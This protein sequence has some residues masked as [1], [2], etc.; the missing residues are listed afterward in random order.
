MNKGI[1]SQ[2]Q[3]QQIVETTNFSYF[4][5][6]SFQN[7]SNLTQN[8]NE[9]LVMLQN[10]LQESIQ[11]AS[12][13]YNQLSSH[14][15]KALTRLEEVK[16]FEIDPLLNQKQSKINNLSR[17]NEHQVNIKRQLISQELNQYVVF[18]KSL[19]K[20]EVDISFISQKAKSLQLSQIERQNLLN[21]YIKDNANKL[22]DQ[23]L[24]LVK[25]KK[26]EWTVQKNKIVG[27]G[28]ACCSKQ[29]ESDQISINPMEAKIQIYKEI[30]INLKIDKNFQK[31]FNMHVIQANLD[32][33]QMKKL[34][35]NGEQAQTIK[36]LLQNLNLIKYQLTNKIN[37][38]RVYVIQ[39]FNLCFQHFISGVDHISTQD[40]FQIN[41]ILQ[42]FINHLK[43]SIFAYP[44]LDLFYLFS[45]LQAI[46]EKDF[47][48][49][50]KFNQIQLISQF[51]SLDMEGSIFEK[52]VQYCDYQ[53]Q[54]VLTAKE[55]AKQSNKQELVQY[56]YY[57]AFSTPKDKTV[58]IW[59]IID[60]V[61]KKIQTNKDIIVRQIGALFAEK[62]QYFCSYPFEEFSFYSKKFIQLS[63]NS[64][65]SQLSIY[66]LQQISY[67]L[68]KYQNENRDVDI[69]QR[70]YILNED[71]SYDIFIKM[72]QHYQLQ[73]NPSE[74][75][76]LYYKF[77]FQD[78]YFRF[79][80]N[81]ILLQLYSL[82]IKKEQIWVPLIYAYATEKN[83]SIKILFY[84]NQN[85]IQDLRK[86]IDDNQKSFALQQVIQYK[87]FRIQ[88]LLGNQIQ[89][90]EIF[91]LEEE[92]L[93]QQDLIEK[94]DFSLI[95][96][97]YLDTKHEF[98][99]RIASQDEKEI[100]ELYIDQY[101]IFLSGNQ[102]FCQQQKQEE[103]N[104][105]NTKSAI[106]IIQDNFLTQDPGMNKKCKIL[107]IT[108]QG[109]SGKSILL[110]KLQ[111]NLMKQKWNPYQQ[112]CNGH[113]DNKFNKNNEN[114]YVIPIFIKFN[115]LS[116][117]NPSINNYLLSM[118]LDKKQI[119][120]LK[121]TKQQK[122]ILLDGY[123]QYQGDYMTIYSQLELEEWNNT[124]IIITSRLEG[125]TID[126]AC[127]YFSQ[128]D[129]FGRVD[130][131]SY[132]LVEFKNLK[133]KDIIYYCNLWDVSMQNRSQN[134]VTDN[135]NDKITNEKQGQLIQKIQKCFQNNQLESILYQP[136]SIHFLVKIIYSKNIEDID[137]LLSDLNEQILIV[138]F[139]F[140][141]YFQKEAENFMSQNI[142]DVKNPM[143]SYS[144]TNQFFEFFQNIAMQMFISKEKYNNYLKLDYQQMR[145]TISQNVFQS[146]QDPSKIQALEL[147]LKQKLQNLIDQGQ[148]LR[149]TNKEHQNQR[150]QTTNPK[151][152]VEFTSKYLYE[153]FSARA[154]KWDFD[155]HEENIYALDILKLEKFNINKKIIMN[156][157]VKQSEQQIIFKFQQLIKH[158]IQ[159]NDFQ[160][161]YINQEISKNNRY[162]QY[163]KRS[164]ISKSTE[165]SK[166]DI[167]SSNMLS[168][169]FSSKF[170][171][172]FLN[173][174][175]CS[176]SRA[177]I[178]FSKSININFQQCNLENSYIDKFNLPCFETSNLKNAISDQFQ[179]VFDLQNIFSFKDIV[180]FKNS[181]L[182][183]ISETGFIN[184]FDAQNNCKNIN[185][186]KSKQ[187][188]CGQLQNIYMINSNQSLLASTK[189]TLFQINPNTFETQNT[190]TFSEE[191]VK[192]SICQ[193]QYVVTLEDQT[194]FYGNIQNGLINLDKNL[195]QGTFSLLTKDYIITQNEN[196]LNMYSLQQNL[197]LIISIPF[198]KNALLNSAISK[199][200]KYIATI[201]EGINI[202]VWDLENE[203]KLV[204]QIQGHTDN[205]LSI[206]FT[207]DVKYLATASMDKTC[208]IW[209]LERGFQLIKTL[210]G[211]TTPIS[212]GAFSD[213]GRFIAT[214]SSE[215][216][217]K[218]WDFSNEFQLINSFEAHS[219]QISQIA[220]SNN[221]KYLATSSWDKTCKIWDINQGFDLTYTLQG[222][223][224][225]I[226]SIAF[227]FDGKYIATGSGD[228]T[229]KIWNVE[230]SFELMHT[231]K[232]HT[233]YVSSV[234][235]SFD[236]KYFATGSSDTTCK[237]WS[238][239]KKFQLLNTIEGHQKFIF[240]I[241]FSPD[242]KYLVT[243]SQDQICKIWDAQNS[244]EFITSIQ[245]NLVAISGDC[246]QIATVC[247]DKVCKIWDTTKQL[248]VIYSFQ[249]HQSQIRSLA[250]SSDSKYLVTCSTDKSCKLWNVQKGYQLKN[251]IKD[252]RTSVSSAAFS[253]DKKFLAVS[254]DDKTFKIW[255]I[256]KEFEIIES[257]LGH[258]DS[259][260]S[261]VYSLD[262]KQF[263]TG[264]ADS[265]CRIWNSEKGFELVKTIKGH[266]KEIT[267]VAFSRDGKYF[268]TS[269]TDK[270]CKIWNINNDYQLIYTI[271]GLLD[272]NS[273]IAFSL[274]SKYL[275]TNYEDKTCKVWSV[276]NNFQVLYTI[277]GHTDFISQ[278]AFSMDQRYLAT[279]SIDQTCKVWNICK[280][281]E[282]FKSLQGHFDQIS[283]V[284]FSPDSSY[285]I[286]GSKDKTCRVWNV[287]KGFEYT[288]LI[289]GH[290][291]QINSIDFSKDSKYLA[292]GSA[293]QTCK[294]WNI[295]KGFL[296]I[297]TILGHFD[298]IS[299]VQF[300][301]NSKYIITSSWDSTCKIWN[302]EKGIQ[303]INM[304]DNL[305]LN[306]KP[307]ALSQDRKYLAIC[308]DNKACKIW[309]L[310]KQIQLINTIN[311]NQGNIQ[312]IAFSADSKF[313]ATSNGD[314]QWKI[315][316]VNNQFTQKN[317]NIEC[318]NNQDMNEIFFIVN[319]D[320][321]GFQQQ[322]KVIFNIREQN[323]NLSDLKNME[324]FEQI[325]QI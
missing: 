217:C 96:K 268:A 291:D 153:Y 249:A 157:G 288:S 213:D 274:D 307:Y 152:Y 113:T 5:T 114:N 109:G 287:N 56:L 191:I 71:Q 311:Y 54:K 204:Q 164:N 125:F 234:A 200:G 271:S 229:S 261:S 166:I 161:T 51:F 165:I 319:N 80:S 155:F 192:I 73:E 308:C 150:E 1:S 316:E 277:H 309:K 214:S 136:L 72:L 77:S 103:E 184:K 201:S 202:K 318:S 270:T 62:K 126:D 123:D 292:T 265:N 273:P 142:L 2:D 178:P 66:L 208:K 35:Q 93:D 46:N 144:I 221:S 11:T 284:N 168:I 227:S 101:F 240:S 83:Q 248:E 264:C 176:F 24:K 87:Q 151:E 228:S 226:S 286:T 180:F 121:E 31:V 294:I 276:N 215:F 314:M 169:L 27:G 283:A 186:I 147:A 299:S 205:I 195:I 106:S 98:D 37:D 158:L 295:D 119:K 310:Q 69:S 115:D 216:I 219:A 61:D 111:A 49:T 304:L 4:N 140:K 59:E 193:D 171:F 282:L 92:F 15:L 188:T 32:S 263:A 297:N 75:F 110:Q 194:K 172:P 124:Y 209:N 48:K 266:S 254:F 28:G 146:L 76:L 127:T 207:S 102:S 182:I 156:P 17:S 135:Q 89:Q 138:D 252:F 301:L 247:G 116:V 296:L 21:L 143:L 105:M 256:E 170:A 29:Y 230:K 260:L 16:K 70:Y 242:S 3:D 107:G 79:L 141:E 199:N 250:Y 239:E 41:E 133:Q 58:K 63:E 13:E 245:G 257:T 190:F 185:L 233:G 8:L 57:A 317:C 313:L 112:R 36:I 225:Q 74:N 132:C 159:S 325:F 33:N 7:F 18:N 251:V 88:N 196:I 19:Q 258:T 118:N 162:I 129:E 9:K 177:Y 148:I 45:F 55:Q 267:S 275:I 6:R 285:L 149:L 289:E 241:Q 68:E 305:S 90:E 85:F 38:Y 26:I 181:I 52:K 324:I 167:G 160:E 10:N 272:I 43:Q 220:F 320:K 290:K 312:Q 212:T 279:A 231:L 12:I 30:D 175:K 174:Q 243:G 139:F 134:Q 47:N 321:Q 203:C 137:T 120:L 183:T 100:N 81:K 179:K 237:I 117:K 255:N 232:G 280:D 154:M 82:N 22:Q 322:E 53:F 224:V 44:C 198:E 23:I 145:F 34:I 197:Q 86:E 262:G 128:E 244:F 278:F 173:L 235:F 50:S 131:S 293:D 104:L 95:E 253:A 65:S 223:T 222:H 206:A 281:F 91:D 130:L 97:W 78:I 20:Y 269:S 189:R 187:I 236:G 238:I 218:V 315:W 60:K 25:K 67:I 246:Q 84:K 210:E 300:S 39:I 163:I 122:L 94:L 306:Q 298:V 323:K 259:V 42:E 14:S 108:A 99:E 40:Q 211:H 64:T 303:F 302:F